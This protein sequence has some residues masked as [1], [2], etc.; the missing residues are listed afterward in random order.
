MPSDDK[1]P[2]TP[3]DAVLADICKTARALGGYLEFGRH[4]IGRY[5]D[6]RNGTVRICLDLVFEPHLKGPGEP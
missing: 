5:E 3:L 2:A 4:S 6:Q 1:A